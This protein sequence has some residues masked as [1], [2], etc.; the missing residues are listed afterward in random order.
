MARSGQEHQGL[1]DVLGPLVGRRS[2]SGFSV[3]VVMNGGGAFGVGIGI[4]TG[5]W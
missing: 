1:G 5:G 4:G 3:V 2:Q